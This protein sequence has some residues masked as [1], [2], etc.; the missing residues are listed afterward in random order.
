MSDEQIPVSDEL[1][2]QARQHHV[3]GNTVEAIKLLTQAIQQDPSNTRVAMDMVQ[4]FIDIGEVAQAASL[5]GRLPDTDKQSDVGRTLSGQL[6]FIELASKTDGREKLQSRVS[7]DAEDYDAVFDLAI[8]LLAENDYEQAVD[9][10]MTIH[11]KAPHYREG[12]AREMIITLS[13]MMMINDPERATAFRRRL[14]NVN[15]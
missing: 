13:N 6:T 11:E 5:Y 8:C 9:H 12:A 7:D 15:N 3:S 1:R 14:G 2:I 4:V 10:L